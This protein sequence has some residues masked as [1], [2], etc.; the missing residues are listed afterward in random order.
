M[1]Q[2]LSTFGKEQGRRYKLLSALLLEG[3]RE[4]KLEKINT[5]FILITYQCLKDRYSVSFSTHEGS[6]NRNSLSE[7][8]RRK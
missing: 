3:L 7:M 1:S 2:Y 8:E 4:G 5:I 6:D